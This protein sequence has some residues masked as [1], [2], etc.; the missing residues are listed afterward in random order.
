M[1]KHNPVQKTDRPLL[2]TYWRRHTAMTIKLNS[3]SGET[4]KRSE[5]KT[6]LTMSIWEPKWGDWWVWGKNAHD[7]LLTQ[8]KQWNQI[9]RSKIFMLAVKLCTNMVLQYVI[10]RTCTYQWVFT[11]NVRAYIPAS[12]VCVCF[13]SGLPVNK[14]DNARAEKSFFE[15]MGTLCS[16]APWWHS[17]DNSMWRLT[18]RS[19]IYRKETN[20]EL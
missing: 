3:G 9:H 13:I 7:N 17:H 19:H 2:L 1:L 10:A 16:W 8:C 14:R 18:N 11:H 4:V 6:E 15:P 5:G 20:E 12:R